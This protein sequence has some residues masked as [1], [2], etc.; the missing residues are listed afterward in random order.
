MERKVSGNGLCAATCEERRNRECRPIKLRW[1]LT[2][3]AVLHVPSAG[4]PQ[5]RCL[6][7]KIVVT[8]CVP[9]NGAVTVLKKTRIIFEGARAGP[10][11]SDSLLRSPGQ[12]ENEEAI[13][14]SSPVV[15]TPV[16]E[17]SAQK[18]AMMTRAEVKKAIAD[19]SIDLPFSPHS[20]LVSRSLSG[21]QLTSNTA[22]V[23]HEFFGSPQVVSQLRDMCSMIFH[24]RDKVETMG[25]RPSSG[26]LVIGAKGTGKSV[27]VKSLS[28]EF[29]AQLFTVSTNEMRRD[30]DVLCPSRAQ[31]R[32]KE[33]RKMLLIVGSTGNPDAIDIALRRPGRFDSEVALEA[34]DVQERLVLLEKFVGSMQLHPSVS[35]RE[36][37]KMTVGYVGANLKSLCSQA[38]GNCILRHASEGDI[39]TG[40]HAVMHSDFLDAMRQISIPVHRD[41]QI[42]VTSTDESQ[43][44]S[45]LGGMEGV[46][47]AL[48]RVEFCASSSLSFPKVVRSLAGLVGLGFVKASGSELFSAYLGES[49]AILRQLFRRARRMKPCIL[50]LD[51]IDAIVG[52]RSLDGS[53]DGTEANGVQQRVLSTLLNEMDGV[54]SSGGVVVVGATNR[55]DMIDAALLRPGRFDVVLEVPV[56]DSHERQEI[57]ATCSRRLPIYVDL[58]TMSD[59]TEGY[60]GAEINRLV[61]EAAMVCLRENMENELVSH[62]HFLEALRRVRPALL[63]GAFD[64]YTTAGRETMRGKG[65]EERERA[66]GL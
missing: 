53:G 54:D 25:I 4:A 47:E 55:L 34:P 61:V 35:T 56:P 28:L 15:S 18:S 40:S 22:K 38:A 16:Q 41:F 37:A 49:E 1:V 62:S 42:Q 3:D 10:R 51:E 48:R 6:L 32:D 46:K 7:G 31:G 59:K 50:F 30:I 24:Q 17:R 58:K 21:L 23:E 65:Q 2:K 13:S 63:T 26:I 9:E 5:S 60:T 27:L 39:H 52:K 43:S 8:S 12:S 64:S 36:L 20:P 19:A 44:M 14:F 66:G 57:L 45:S 33:A 11:L 29:A